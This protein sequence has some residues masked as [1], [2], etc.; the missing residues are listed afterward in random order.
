MKRVKRQH[1]EWEEI[2]ASHIYDK[3]SIPRIQTELLKLNNNNNRKNKQPNSQMGK[4]LGE[5]F[6]QR[7]YL[8][9]QSAHEKMLR[10]T[11]HQGD[12]NKN[13]N[14]IPH[15]HQ[16]GDYLKKQKTTTVDED[17]EILEPLCSVGGNLK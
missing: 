16:D 11:K 12:A 10:I 5:T 3:G 8:N 13:Y 14:E 7:R 9:G 2:F 6:L 15:T 1:T 17:V 4:G